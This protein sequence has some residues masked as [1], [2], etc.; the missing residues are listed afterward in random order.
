ME[1]KKIKVFIDFEAITNNFLKRI[2]RKIDVP[3]LPYCYTVGMYKNNDSKNAFLIKSSL[4]SFKNFKA[5]NYVIKLKQN[6]LNDLSILA[7]EEITLKNIDEKIEFYGWNPQM[8]NLILNH[9]FNVP[10]YNA[11]QYRRN[12]PI[13]LS[14]KTVVPH[15]GEQHYFAE[16][17]RII[18]SKKAG[19]DIDIFNDPGFAAAFLGYLRF[20]HFNKIAL[21]KKGLKLSDQDF[22]KIDTDI[23]NYNKD[24]VLKLDYCYKN[25]SIIMQ[26]SKK[27]DGL[28]QD[29]NK[30]SS[31]LKN[32]K[33]SLANFKKIVDKKAKFNP[34]IQVEDLKQMAENKIAQYNLL[35]KF[36]KELPD[37]IV[38]LE[39]AIMWANLKIESTEDKILQAKK[40]K[41]E[42]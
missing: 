10:C 34:S 5:K 22:Q 28:N 17:K 27:L 2:P 16:T 19:I 30:H 12:K 3:F 4:M 21:P 9:L 41:Q 18:K 23:I 42:M 32:Q 6:I 39:E 31:L 38:T 15:D 35:L 37:N 24:D 33:Q 20:L 11:S 29:I 7:K 13:S 36:I 26:R 25:Q 14:L 40:E 8:E 1:K